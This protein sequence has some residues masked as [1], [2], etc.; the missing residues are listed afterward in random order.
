MAIVIKLRPKYDEL[1]A[2]K[3]YTYGQVIDILCEFAETLYPNIAP[4]RIREIVEKNF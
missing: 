1:R 4:E 3:T 2:K